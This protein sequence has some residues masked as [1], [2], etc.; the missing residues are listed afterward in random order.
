[1]LREKGELESREKIEYESRARKWKYKLKTC[2][3]KVKE[4]LRNI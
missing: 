3:E 4:K 1:M 2:S